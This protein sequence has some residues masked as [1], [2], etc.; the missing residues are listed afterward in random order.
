MH[1]PHPF[2]P[3]WRTLKV[4]ALR[5]WAR[6]NGG[7]PPHFNEFTKAEVVAWIEKHHPETAVGQPRRL[8]CDSCYREQPVEVGGD[9]SVVECAVCGYRIAPARLLRAN[10]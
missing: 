9:G 5:Q 10:R 8:Y 3:N 2:E 7:G 4:T 6:T 1:E